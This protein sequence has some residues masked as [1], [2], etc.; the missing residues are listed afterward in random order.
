MCTAEG[1]RDAEEVELKLDLPEGS[2]PRIEEIELLRLARSRRETKIL[3]SVYFDTP[4]SR[5]RDACLS[6]RVRADGGS[7]IRT[8]KQAGS[9]S[10]G[11]QEW[12][13]KIATARPDFELARQSGLRP[14]LSKKI[15]HKLRPA[16]ETQV[17]RTLYPL[18]I[19]NNVIELA[20]DEGHVNGAERDEAIGEIEVELKKGEPAPLFELA[21][22]LSER[23]PLRLVTRSKAARGYDLLSNRS[24]VS[25]VKS[26]DITLDRSADVDTAFQAIANAC[27]NQIADNYSAVTS[28]DPEGG[29]QMRVGLRRLRAAMSIFK[30]MLKDDESAHIKHELKWLT[31]ELG[32]ARQFYVYNEGVVS[33]LRRSGGRDGA[34][35]EFEAFVRAQLADGDAKAK[36]AVSSDRYRGLLLQTAEWIDVGFWRLRKDSRTQ[37]VRERDLEKFASRALTKRAR[38]IVK[39]GQALEKNSARDRH[40]FRIACKKLRYGTEFFAS[41]LLQEREDPRRKALKKLKTLLDCLGALTDVSAHQ[42]FNASMIEVKPTLSPNIAFDSG[43]G[44]ASEE[45]RT[46]ELVCA[47]V[48]AYR[49]FASVVPERSF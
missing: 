13:W 34:F 39:R 46:K 25:P 22:S 49:K 38:K 28:G 47:S 36:Q 18:E 21:R 33:R 30:K 5:L 8:I 20:I 10:G 15:T 7:Y 12:E 32:S 1:K 45:C 41:V 31:E 29:H 43:R 3:R 24:S 2:R 42:K 14:F 37:M 9:P 40:K 6:L 48:R 35:H 27:L 16:F 19:G 11:R 17:E 4:N 23:A 26:A 44:S